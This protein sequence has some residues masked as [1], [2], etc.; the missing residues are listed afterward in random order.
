MNTLGWIL[1]VFAH[2]GAMGNGDSNALTTAWFSTQ[3]K[4]EDAGKAARKLAEGSVKKIEYA[5]KPQ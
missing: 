5:C 2:V 3:A 1:I 4:C